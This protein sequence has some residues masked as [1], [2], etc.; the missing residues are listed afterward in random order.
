MA[1][2]R[3]FDPRQGSQHI[4]VQV[5]TPKPYMR[6]DQL[7]EVRNAVQATSLQTLCCNPLSFAPTKPSTKICFKQASN[8][9]IVLSGLV[10]LGG[11]DTR[12][13]SVA[14][15]SLAVTCKPQGD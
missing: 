2:A 15:I 7:Q 14:D 10:K 5:R 13:A 12:V 3:Y 1:F 8:K 9:F 6:H 11:S 4:T